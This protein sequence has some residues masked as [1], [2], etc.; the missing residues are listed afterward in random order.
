MKWFKKSSH[1]DSEDKTL[2]EKNG[3]SKTRLKWFSRNSH[4]N[5]NSATA[6]EISNEID[7][8]PRTEISASRQALDNITL[9]LNAN[10]ESSGE[11]GITR[12]YR[13]NTV[14]CDN[15]YCCGAG[16]ESHSHIKNADHVDESIKNFKTTHDDN[17]KC[18]RR[19]ST[20]LND[21]CKNLYVRREPIVD[22]GK[23][24][25]PDS[26][27]PSIIDWPSINFQ[28]EKFEN[29]EYNKKPLN[30]KVLSDIE[31]KVEASTY[32]IVNCMLF[33]YDYRRDYETLGSG[34]RKEWKLEDFDDDNKSTPMNEDTKTIKEFYRLSELNDVLLHYHEIIIVE[35]SQTIECMRFKEGFFDFLSW[36]IFK[37]KEIN[38]K[39]KVK[40][41]KC[42][43]LRN[44]LNFFS[45]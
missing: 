12:K 20:K 38:E 17:D 43:W 9:V 6:D 2:K 32:N 45:K 10:G 3:K 33:N 15:K 5:S 44:I 34:C 16:D 14:S 41:G 25:V 26:M 19:Q 7:I 30:Y 8:V 13:D 37:G 40:K 21:E 42:L 11:V 28:D 35:A 22:Y 4:N 27:Y 23:L 36:L 31:H 1:S 29:S 18:A 39:H 24:E